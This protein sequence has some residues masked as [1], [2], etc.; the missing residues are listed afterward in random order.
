MY[1]VPI[2]GRLKYSRFRLRTVDARFWDAGQRADLPMTAHSIMS[3][4][5]LGDFVLLTDL[6]AGLPG[7]ACV[8]AS[9]RT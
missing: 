8:H 6:P 3:D 9:I 2:A 7:R 1:L 5:R 4:E